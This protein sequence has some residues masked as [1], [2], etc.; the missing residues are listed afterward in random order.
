[1]EKTSADNIAVDR[2]VNADHEDHIKEVNAVAASKGQGLSGY[3]ALTPWQT[4]KAFK[5]C[6]AICFLVAF[7]AAT[8]GYQIGYVFSC[9]TGD[10][11]W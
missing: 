7:S 6:T 9:R 3:E 2:R 10:G 11:H 5:F 1:M 8:D 4:V